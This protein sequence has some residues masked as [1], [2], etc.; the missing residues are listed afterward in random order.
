MNFRAQART[1]D[2]SHQNNQSNLISREHGP[3]VN[4][5]RENQLSLERPFNEGWKK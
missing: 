3:S 1:V 5:L 4:S 2:S